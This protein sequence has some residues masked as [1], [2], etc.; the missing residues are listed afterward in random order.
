MVTHVFI[1]LIASP[2]ET[3]HYSAIVMFRRN[4]F[5]Q[6]ILV[7]ITYYYAR[8]GRTLNRR[9]IWK[10]WVVVLNDDVIE[11]RFFVTICE[12]PGHDDNDYYQV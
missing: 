7:I 12:W 11:E 2:I 6:M 5:I 4:D 3:E 9:N 1:K 8:L 10:F